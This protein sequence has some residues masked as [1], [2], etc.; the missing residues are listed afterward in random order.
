MDKAGQGGSERR[1]TAWKK[2]LTRSQRW[3]AFAGV[4]L[5]IVAALYV[6]WE[7]SRIRARREA[8]LATSAAEAS[9]LSRRE[10]EILD[11]A[12]AWMVE[13][14][15]PD[16]PGDTAL[17]ELSTAGAIEAFFA[18][19]GLYVRAAQPDTRPG[20][21][22]DAI[23][24]SPKDAV[25]LCMLAPPESMS[26][27]DLTVTA[28]RALPGT[29]A[30]V[31][32]TSRVQRLETVQRGLRVLMPGWAD[33]V[34]AADPLALRALEGELRDRTAEVMRAAKAWAAAAYIAIVI[35]ELPSGMKVEEGGTALAES[36]RGAMLKAVAGK[37]HE[38]RV[39]IY[40]IEAKKPVL[41]A[42]FKVDPE[43][44]AAR[45]G[46]AEAAAAQDCYLGAMA[47]KTAQQ[48]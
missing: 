26:D 24:S 37:A 9:S 29:P 42:R 12:R 25:V 33:E 47:R 21:I 1:S 23:R 36:F 28:G 20:F 39:A 45:T 4:L 11:L 13:T 35:D 3:V 14:A 18:R 2:R 17:R 34:K 19:P 5:V 38:A 16:Y 32:A 31:E 48:I 22:A 44:F 10:A 6:V 30:F 40:D 46:S 7:R 27:Y 43:G 15:A 8:L 41:R